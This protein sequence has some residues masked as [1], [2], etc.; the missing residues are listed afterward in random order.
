MALS[1]LYSRRK[2]A[3]EVINDPTVT[4]HYW[5]YRVHINIEEMT[6]DVPFV[7]LVKGMLV[8]SGRATI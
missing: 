5:R 8:D 6:S 3:E 7:Q 1:P 2:A 4:K